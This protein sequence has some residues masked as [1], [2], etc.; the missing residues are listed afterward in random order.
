MTSTLKDNQARLAARMR[1]IVALHD[2][3]RAVSSV[4]DLDSVS[5]KIVDAVARTFDVQIVALW[6][7]DQDGKLRISAARTRRPDTTA[8]AMDD[9]VTTAA[10]ALNEIAEQ[11]RA[12]RTPARFEKAASDA[13]HGAAAKAAGAPGPLVALPLDRKARVVGV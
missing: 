6:L 1:E 2:A 5:R 8:L 11:V 10:G 13:T 4:I 12:S 9:A 3:G 7:I